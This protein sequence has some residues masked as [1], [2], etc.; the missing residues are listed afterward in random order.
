MQA[1]LDHPVAPCVTAWHQHER[2]RLF[3]LSRVSHVPSDILQDSHLSRHT[4]L[5]YEHTSTPR[6]DTQQET[7]LQA[8]ILADPFEHQSRYGPLIRGGGQDGEG[9][10]DAQPWVRRPSHS[11]LAP[12]G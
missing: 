7:I 1:M 3:A 9:G 2:T 5:T 4:A 11:P 8:V 6:M 10:E 12:P